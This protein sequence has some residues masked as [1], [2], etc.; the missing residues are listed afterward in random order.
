MLQLLN[1]C[2]MTKNQISPFVTHSYL[3]ERESPVGYLLLKCIR[4]YL[5][6]DSYL[7]M[8]VHTED[9]MAEGEVELLK[10]GEHLNVSS[11]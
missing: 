6:V 10:F 2:A 11:Y 3:E 4:S 7:T 5:I 1:C 9:T 8:A